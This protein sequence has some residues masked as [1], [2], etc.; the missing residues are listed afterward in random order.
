MAGKKPCGRSFASKVCHRGVTQFR[1]VSVKVAA[2]GMRQTSPEPPPLISQPCSVEPN[3]S[4][5][6]LR[7]IFYFKHHHSVQ[8]GLRFLLYNLQLLTVLHH[9]KAELSLPGLYSPLVS[10]VFLQMFDAQEPFFL[11][12]LSYVTLFDVQTFSQETK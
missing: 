3:P 10:H 6:I 4:P 9:I 1:L 5:V 8:L 11:C 2:D 12:C 7:G